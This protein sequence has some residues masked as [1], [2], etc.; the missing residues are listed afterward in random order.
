MP[1]ARHSG[2]SPLDTAILRLEQDPLAE[3]EFEDEVRKYRQDP[4]LFF[5]D[6][7]KIRTKTDGLIPFVLNRPQR[8]LL[9]NWILPALA[10]G[11]P[12]RLY[13]LKARQM[14]FSTLSEALVYW[15]TTLW[16][17]SNGLVTAHSRGRAATIFNMFRVYFTNAD[18]DFRPAQKLSNRAEFYFTNPD[19]HG[20]PGIESHIVTETAEN[21]DLGAGGTWHI[22]HMSEFARYER[23]NNNLLE[24]W[25]SLMPAIPKAANTFV[26]LETTAQG[27]GFAKDF[28]YEDNGYE[29]AFIPWVAEPNYRL[30]PRLSHDELCDD[31]DDKFGNE[32]TLYP[33]VEAA[34]REWW[35]DEM[36]DP[37]VL[38]HETLCRLTWRRA[39]LADFGYDVSLFDQEYPTTPE[40]AFRASGGAVFSLRALEA[41]NDRV[42]TPRYFS[43]V[44]DQVPEK[45][46][47]PNLNGELRVFQPPMAGHQYIAGVDVAGGYSDGD[48][49]VVQLL[50]RETMALVATYQ[51]KIDP[52]SYSHL[53]DAL[54]RRYNEAFLVVEA[55]N[56]GLLVM[57]N[58]TKVLK[59]PTRR[60]YRRWAYDQVMQKK[61]WVVGF[62]TSVATKPMIIN[63]LR[64]AISDQTLQIGDAATVQEL[65]EYQR[66]V[67]G[68]KEVY[69]A[70]QGK[71]DDLVIG[72][73]L[74][75]H[76]ALQTDQLDKKGPIARAAG[77]TLDS[78]VRRA[79]QQ[80]RRFDYDQQY[81]SV[82]T[83]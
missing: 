68:V 24:T 23:V 17:Y 47:I 58:L 12:I 81:G 56:H 13:V 32:V 9:R 16:P 80:Q 79:Q 66:I 52:D 10:E 70:P 54:G 65:R 63:S 30:E 26:I 21:P 77:W 83:W 59:Y 2:L 43:F 4:E 57:H 14:G 1:R 67:K 41:M 33:L 18:R 73:A 69:E 74:A 35:P 3:G 78:V 61:G 60:L 6:H 28:W 19:Q 48:Y 71:H 31:D 11:R 82:S 49:S 62:Q 37:V 39:T 53:V 22:V 29:K 36:Q 44:R 15:R 8:L 27:E 51:G 5:K 50:D 42:E 40:H 38:H 76:G 64:A 34:L 72:L 7:L 46:F 25:A 55:N 20:E 75:H 45:S